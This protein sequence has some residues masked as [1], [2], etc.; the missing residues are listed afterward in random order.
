MMTNLP[1]HTQVKIAYGLNLITIGLTSTPSL[2]LQNI[3]VVTG[4]TAL[5]LAYMIDAKAE[6]D[7][8]EAGHAIYLI[9]TIWIWSLFLLVVLIGAETVILLNGNST[10]MDALAERMING[11]LPSYNELRATALSFFEDNRDLV[12]STLI[13]WCAPAQLYALLRTLR[14]FPRA[15]KNYRLKN[16]RTWF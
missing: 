14:A 5:V 11:H 3:G 6:K 13:L 16:P 2:W 4:V 15:L 9:R 7:S 8:A 1:L 10:A 12:I